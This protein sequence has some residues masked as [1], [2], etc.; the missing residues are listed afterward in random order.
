MKNIKWLRWKDPLISA[1]GE[2]GDEPQ[3]IRYTP[4]GHTTVK[5]NSESKMSFKMYIGHTNFDLTR[6]VLEVIK[7]VDGV[8]ILE[9]FSPYQFRVSIGRNFLTRK[10]LREITRSVCDE[11]DYNFTPKARISILHEKIDLENS[12]LW[13][14]IYC[15]PNGVMDK[16]SSADKSEVTHRINNYYQVEESIGGVVLTNL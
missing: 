4:F 14:A 5:A 9:I 10:V 2:D 1:T 15:F 7:D 6:E 8:E 16:F 3:L 12:G 11:E 13:W